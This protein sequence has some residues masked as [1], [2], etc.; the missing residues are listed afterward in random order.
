M[1]F[2]FTGTGNSRYAANKIAEGTGD[3]VADMAELLKNGKMS[4]TVKTGE[5]LG[6][7]FPI[8]YSGLSSVVA[9]FLANINIVADNDCYIYAVITCGASA[10]GADVMFRKAIG[11]YAFDTSY[12][13]E[14]KMPDNYVMLYDPCN[15][16]KAKK[17]MAHA[18]RDICDI[19]EDLQN[20]KKGGFNS[21]AKGK[22][23]SFVMQKAY[24]L[25]R[26]TK[27]FY[28]TDECISCGKCAKDCPIDII[29]MQDGKPTW[30]ASKCAH[31]TACI[32]K[33]PTKAIQ[34]GKATVNRGRYCLDKQ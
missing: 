11:E 17:F 22:M 30:T 10:V 13:Y 4:Y 27:P 20:N 25:M 1:I 3:S 7:V 6:F 24:A 12:V 29:K 5:K 28:V 18:D 26:V 19:I 31:C 14:L 21:G 34:F 16:E 9:D 2:Y 8:Y 32:N 23:M 15:E 33:C